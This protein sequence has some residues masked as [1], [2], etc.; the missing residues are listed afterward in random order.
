MMMPKVG[1]K[2][3]SLARFWYITMKGKPCIFLVNTVV[4]G[5]R[6]QQCIVICLT[7]ACQE[8]AARAKRNV[9]TLLIFLPFPRVT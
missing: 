3:L 1:E 4:S 8:G 2:C 5:V 7:A 6:T 9:A